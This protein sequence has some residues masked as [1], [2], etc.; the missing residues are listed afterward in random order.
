M[1]RA[2]VRA[3]AHVA[4]LVLWVVLLPELGCS[5]QD[6]ADASVSASEA[7]AEKPTKPA[8]DFDLKGVDGRPISLAEHRGKPVVVDFW[9]TWCVPCIYQI[10]EL[11]A[12]WKIHREAGDVAVIGVA[13]DVEGASVV[14]PWIEKEGV[15][16]QI[17]I[18]DE[19]LARQFGVMGF[20]TLAIIS[21][22]GNIESLHV[23]LIEVEELE[24][25]LAPY[26]D[27]SQPHEP[28]L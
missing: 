26:I 25:L 13:V 16:Y 21:S 17:A 27:S 18:G 7:A 4:I 20:P 1:T 2:A 3:G 12:F 5:A 23:G 24:R 28:A 6:G 22:D 10:P 14:G 8:P 15:E 19:S 9:A 11:N